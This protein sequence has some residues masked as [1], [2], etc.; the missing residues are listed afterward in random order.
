MRFRQPLDIPA[1]L[2]TRRCAFNWNKGN[3]ES[4]FVGLRL[5]MRVLKVSLFA[6]AVLLLAV[7]PAA[8]DVVITIDKSLTV[9]SAGLGR[10][11]RAPA[12]T[13]PRVAAIPRSEWRR[14]IPQKSGTTRR[15]RIPSSLPRGA[16]QS[17]AVTIPSVW[18][19]PVPHGCVRLHPANAAKLYALVESRGIATAKVVVTG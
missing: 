15:C 2:L 4:I 19:G 18:G 14:T 16:M 11:L 5:K 7:L 1:Y 10:S 17:T 3:D 6:T 9:Q 8:A 12:A 13:T